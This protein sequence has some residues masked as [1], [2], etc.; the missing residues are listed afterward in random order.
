MRKTKIT[1]KKLPAK[2]SK[3]KVLLSKTKKTKA[4]KAVK[5][6]SGVKKKSALKKKV[7]K[8]KT[9][10]KKI[11]KK[12]A[13]RKK[14]V[15]NKKKTVKKKIA[16]K[17]I[18]KKKIKKT[19]SSKKISKQKLPVITKKTKEEI[20]VKKNDTPVLNFNQNFLESF[21]NVDDLLNE[22]ELSLEKEDFILESDESLISIKMSEKKEKLEQI[23]SED[24]EVSEQVRMA[25]NYN[26]KIKGEE[27]EVNC[28]KEVPLKSNHVVNLRRS[29]KKVILSEKQKVDFK[30]PQKKTI[31][32]LSSLYFKE[33]SHLFL[34][35]D[36]FRFVYFIGQGVVYIFKYSFLGII[37]SFKI[38]L[39]FFIRMALFFNFT[40]QKIHGFFVNFDQEKIDKNRKNSQ[41]KVEKFK[42]KVFSFNP[43]LLFQK[44]SLKFY[45][46][47]FSFVFVALL[48]VSSIYLFGIVNSLQESKGKV[49]GISEQAYQNFNDGL[50]SMMDSDFN[51]AQENFSQANQKFSVAE[52]EISQHSKVIMDIFRLI[53]VGGR[54]L[55]DGMKLLKAGSLMSKSAEHISLA[56][57]KQQEISITDKIKLISDNLTQSKDELKLASEYIIDININSLPAEYREQFKN[58]KNQLP[59]LSDNLESL[60]SFFDL[61]MKILGSEGLQRYLFIFQNNNEIRA[62]GG[63]IGSLATVDLSEGEIVNIYVPGG[64]PYDYKAGIK[65]DY[66]SP[67]PLWLINP[68]FCFWDMNWWSDGPTSFATVLENFSEASNQSLDGLIALNSDIMVDI[69]GILGPIYLEEFDLEITKENFYQKV[70][71]EV[72]INYDR[73]KNQPKEIIGVLMEKVMDR[74]FNDESL[75]YLEFVKLFDLA[76]NQKDVQMYFKDQ[77]LQSSIENYGWSGSV[78]KTK[79]DYLS[80]VNTNIGGQKTDQFIDQDIQHRVDILS[81]GAIIDTVKIK[82]EYKA[83]EDN[84]FSQVPNKNYLRVYVPQG[85]KL[86]EVYGFENFPESEYLKPSYNSSEFL[87]IS[88]I[89]GRVSVDKISGLEIYE[90]FG[91]TVFSGWQEIEPGES[92][93]IYIRYQLPFNIDLSSQDRNL[94]DLFFNTK[95]LSID[96]YSIIY[97]KQS[98]QESEI[99]AY[100]K[101]PK[102]VDLIWSN[103]KGSTISRN[104][105]EDFVVGFVLEK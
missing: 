43:L 31:S 59:A 9:S 67:K 44:G 61:S 95:E 51:L 1:K 56:L 80:V 70:Q 14:S 46:K 82:R 78:T 90:S 35:S 47:T 77:G 66:I 74:V 99:E 28:Q 20:M 71:Q 37:F 7:F 53:P 15:K 98:G 8:K 65:N 97:Q 93:E 102:N 79:K 42:E 39:S 4:K 68:R 21:K 27:I 45:A 57:E 6:K 17:L 52:K 48:I 64:G 16:K 50:Q 76:V 104:F 105:Q 91:K 36:F 88:E 92:K 63:F 25:E 30:I 100:Y 18:L 11:V 62:T 12:S 29:E 69:L 96:T 2:K 87:Q 94:K 58:I 22:A 19:V 86:L 55:D 84:I 73:E 103:I 60:D 32:N 38:L 24:I 83:K 34:K 33:I 5:K 10:P 3:K 41:E 101:W 26:L 75:N 72:E 81:N 89:E 40:G 85:S 13:T 23:I 49:L 54:Q